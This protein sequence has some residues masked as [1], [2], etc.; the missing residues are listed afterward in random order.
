MYNIKVYCSQCFIHLKVRK[1]CY[2]RRNLSL[3]LRIPT[4]W[5][6]LSRPGLQT[7]AKK[8][9]LAKQETSIFC[10]YSFKIE[11]VYPFSVHMLIYKN[12]TFHDI[13]IVYSP[14]P[15]ALQKVIS[16]KCLQ[17]YWIFALYSICLIWLKRFSNSSLS[18]FKDFN[19]R[20]TCF[21]IIV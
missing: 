13:V 5:N 20:L 11:N 2:F 10:P 8:K 4:K 9:I 17:K 19:F 14:C 6:M 21:F 7:G 12:L 18:F 16:I 3:R 15:V 1:S